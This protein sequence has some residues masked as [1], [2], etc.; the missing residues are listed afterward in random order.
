VRASRVS[1]GV[2]PILKR[3][4]LPFAPTESQGCNRKWDSLLEKSKQK[5]HGFHGFHGFAKNSR[6]CTG[7][8]FLVDGKIIVEIKA[9]AA[10]IAEHYAHALHYLTATGLRLAL[11]LNFGARPLQFKRIIRQAFLNPCNPW[12]FCF[13]AQFALKAVA[14]Y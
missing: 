12:R 13:L 9:T 14:S 2:T 6:S 1:C 3:D 10:V 7:A 4:Y 8:D 11:L 5:R